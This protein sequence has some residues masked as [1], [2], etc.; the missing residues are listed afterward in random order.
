MPVRRRT[1]APGPGSVEKSLAERLSA[2]VTAGS[3]EWGL[4]GAMFHR[5]GFRMLSPLFR[6]SRHAI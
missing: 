6:L 5:G 2:T 4:W 1:D 3:G